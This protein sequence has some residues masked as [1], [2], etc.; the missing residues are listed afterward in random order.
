MFSHTLH[1]VLICIF[2]L[3]PSVDLLMVF[4]RLMKQKI[5]QM[6]IVQTPKKSEFEA[7]SSESYLRS[8]I[9]RKTEVQRGSRRKLAQLAIT[10][11][12]QYETLN[13]MQLGMNITHLNANKNNPQLQACDDCWTISIESWFHFCTFF[14]NIFASSYTFPWRY[15]ISRCFAGGFFSCVSLSTLWCVR[16]PWSNS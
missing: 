13:R 15:R 4:V 10:V 16:I 14:W 1:W 12:F 11:R 2:P 5:F 6:L 7:F 3:V 8:E 9:R